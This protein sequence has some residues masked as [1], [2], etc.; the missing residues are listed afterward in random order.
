MAAQAVYWVCI[1]E[2]TAHWEAHLP[3]LP[4]QWGSSSA[5]RS[6]ASALPPLHTWLCSPM[7]LEPCSKGCESNKQVAST[8]SALH[9]LGMLEH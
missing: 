9:E 2:V 7:R 1:S 5:L 3:W 4:H 8:T 6:T